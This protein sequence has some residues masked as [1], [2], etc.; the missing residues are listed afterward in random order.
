[1][2]RAEYNDPA[3]KKLPPPRVF[4]RLSIAVAALLLAIGGLSLPWHG[5]RPARPPALLSSA[6]GAGALRAGA[7]EASIDLPA[8]A[9]IGGFARLSFRSDGVRDPVNARALYLEV[10]GCRVALASVDAVLV[11][12]PLARR[13]QALV[14]NP[15]LDAV[16][17]GA[18]HT[19]AG[20]GGYQDDVVWERVG[21]GP[22]DARI[23]DLLAGRIAEA[24]RRALAASSPARLSVAR[25]LAP[26]LARA[27]S[28]GE[29]DGHV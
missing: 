16:L 7:A 15:K 27:R 3:L 23:F 18:A 17:V 20:P 10:P 5:A 11:T 6:R 26:A 4:S 8:G 29:V 28:G 24:V 14:S 9:P 25:G 1:M 21:L 19:H 12:E 2:R 13:V 22:W